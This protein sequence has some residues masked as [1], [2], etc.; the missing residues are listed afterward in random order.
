MAEWT[1]VTSGAS[2]VAG[3]YD[4]R[5][6]HGT[7]DVVLTPPGGLP[8]LRRFQLDPGAGTN[9]VTMIVHLT[10][11][12]ALI[13]DAAQSP[14]TGT[15]SFQVT[16]DAGHRYEIKSATNLAPPNWS[17]V[18]TEDN[19]WGTIV[20]TNGSPSVDAMRHFRAEKLP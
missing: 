12:K 2:N 5:G 16:G 3:E 18:A 9:D 15:F 11:E 6:F 8:T 19:P 4:F 1:T 10:G 17:P 20:Y 7:Y 14:A 13:H